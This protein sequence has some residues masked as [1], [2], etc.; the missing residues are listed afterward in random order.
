MADH[1]A[2]P[3]DDH[4]HEATALGP[5]DVTMWGAAA[6]G[7]VLGLVVFVALIQAVL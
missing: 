7:V 2:D 4:G 3:A 5:V 6:L 1:P